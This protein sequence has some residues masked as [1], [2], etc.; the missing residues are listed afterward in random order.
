M[1]AADPHQVAARK[2]DLNAVVGGRRGHGRRH[3]RD[4]LRRQ[5]ERGIDRADI[6]RPRIAQPGKDEIG[7]ALLQNS[8]C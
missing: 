3:L 6:R 7:A 5:K 2:L 1:N 8:V 4:D